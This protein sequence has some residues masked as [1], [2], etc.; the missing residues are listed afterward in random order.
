MG[1]GFWEMTFDLNGDELYLHTEL[2]AEFLILKSTG[3]SLLC[4]TPIHMI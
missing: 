2:L 4:P 1:L 3:Y